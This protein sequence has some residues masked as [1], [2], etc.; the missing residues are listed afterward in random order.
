M[1][2]FSVCSVEVET[3]KTD[4]LLCDNRVCVV[5]CFVYIIVLVLTLLVGLLKLLYIL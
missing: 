5:V 4:F 2:I 1:K 3:G